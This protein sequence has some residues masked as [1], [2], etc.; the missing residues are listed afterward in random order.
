MRDTLS[1]LNHYWGYP[2]FRPLQREI[3]DSVMAGRDTLALLPT[4]AGK[5]VCYQV[6]AIALPGITLVVSPL[7]ALMQ[8]QVAR[9]TQLGVAAASLHSGMSYGEVKQVLSD[10]VHDGYKLL[11]V[12]PERLQTR[13]FTDYFG[14]MSV[15]LIAV[16]E[17][18]C[19]SQWGHDFR[20]SYLKVVRLRDFFPQVPLLALTATA[21]P[22]VK[23]DLIAGLGLRRPAEFQQS[24]AR[25]NIFQEVCYT[26]NKSTD[27]L[28]SVDKSCSIV[29][30]R[31]RRRTETLMRY[32]EQSGLSVAGYHAGMPRTSR[33]AAQK[34]WME[35]GAAVMVATTA[36]GMGIDKPEVRMVLHYDAPEH[37]ESY[38]QE[39]GRA[40]R[41]GLP[42]IALCLY[43][44]EDINR[45]RESTAL[46]FPNEAYIRQVYQSV[47]EYLQIPIGCEPDQYYSFDLVDFCQ[48]FDLQPAAALP[49]LR[50]LERENLWTLTESVTTPA[51]IRLLVERGAIDDLGRY[52]E[53]LEYIAVGLLRMYPTLF[54]YPTPVFEGAICKR[55]AIGRETLAAGLAELKRMGFIQ[56]SVPS[57]GP[58][59]FFHHYRVDSRHLTLNMKKVKDLRDR[60]V[61]RTEAMI[62]I[63]ENTEQCREVLLLRYF[64]E[65]PK[66]DCGH[67]DI[68]RDRKA[69]TGR[70]VSMD[71]AILKLVQAHP[72]I[73]LR[74]V[75][76]AFEPSAYSAAIAAVRS[77]MDR[78]EVR[79][80]PN[81]TLVVGS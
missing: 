9:L 19:V 75:T 39:M 40:G 34:S 78:G 79:L 21:T 55:L 18:H 33:D 14:D 13:L 73:A 81:G 48:K 6:P 20:P 42:S 76:A 54:F 74:E 50:L 68:C 32:L 30:T 41:D 36:F 16:D 7:I 63:L 47:A 17:A 27:T 3:I 28:H 2:S 62:G 46:M 80:S 25:N 29:Y 4:G 60:H 10:A 51:T 8:D 38:F 5:S 35:G 44:G 31:S 59:M 22:D 37:P 1:I 52:R 70:R 65:V 58:Q 23:A 26:E 11:Y 43:N 53:D 49:A 24:F 77:L 71:A 72:G 61:T 67:C 56:Y 45:L 12:S 57:E 66:G 69:Q 64:G 15:S